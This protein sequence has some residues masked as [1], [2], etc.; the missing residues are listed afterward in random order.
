MTSA[1]FRSSTA[2][3]SRAGTSTL[4]AVSAGRTANPRHFRVTA[5]QNV[6]LLDVE[7]RQ[8]SIVDAILA[9]NGIAAANSVRGLGRL[10]MACPALPTCGLAV[11]EAERALPAIIDDLQAEFDAVGLGD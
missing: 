1:S 4:A 10:A 2:T 9:G 3:A 5:N 8:R 7:P 11:T 6:Y